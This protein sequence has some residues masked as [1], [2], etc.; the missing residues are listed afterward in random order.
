M[1]DGAR[2]ETLNEIDR[3]TTYNYI[4]GFLEKHL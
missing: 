1:V 4:L 3:I 2:H